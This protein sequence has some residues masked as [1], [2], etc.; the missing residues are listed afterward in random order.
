MTNVLLFLLAIVLNRT[1][2]AIVK[3]KKKECAEDKNK[4]EQLISQYENEG[5]AYEGGKFD[6]TVVIHL[7]FQTTRGRLEQTQEMARLYELSMAD[8]LGVATVNLYH[9]LWLQQRGMKVVVTDGTTA[10]ELDIFHCL[11]ETVP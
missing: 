11:D 3:L 7:Q 2:N 9:Q 10:Y 1:A 5:T 4:L 8:F 6:E